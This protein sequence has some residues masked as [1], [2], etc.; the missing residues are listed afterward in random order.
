LRLGRR[1]K[2]AGHR[3]KARVRGESVHRHDEGLG[4]DDEAIRAIVTRLARSH[5]SGGG[6]IERAAIVAE[7]SDAG[8]IIAWIIAHAG[9]PEMRTAAP[10]GR[11]LHGSRLSSSGAGG[12]ETPLRSVLPANALALETP[13]QGM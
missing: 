7:G 6:V 2:S 8:A 5:P 1:G 9:A 3:R 10:R 4:I 11:G 13:R 12:S